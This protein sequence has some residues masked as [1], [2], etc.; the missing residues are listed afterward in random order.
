MIFVFSYFEAISIK[1]GFNWLIPHIAPVLGMTG[2]VNLIG[3]AGVAKEAD[4]QSLRFVFRLSVGITIFYFLVIPAAL[5]SSYYQV[6][7]VA[8]DD[9]ENMKSTAMIL[10]DYNIVIGFIQGLI[11]SVM[12]LFFAK[13]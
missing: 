10:A 12:G 2:A 9:L 8:P 13:T 11:A 5:V 4:F 7:T 1:D 3:P 6:I